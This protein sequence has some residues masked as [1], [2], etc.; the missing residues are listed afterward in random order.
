[1]VKGVYFDLPAYALSIKNGGEAQSITI[2]GD[3]A[4]YGD[5]VI[6]YVVEQG[7]SPGVLTVDGKIS[8]HGQNS[9]QEKIE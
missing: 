5:H 7:G 4:T 6:S 3:I 1:M 9:Q 8:A 2:K